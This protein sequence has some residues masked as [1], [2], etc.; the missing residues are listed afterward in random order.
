MQGV[1]KE[2]VLIEKKE[3]K[4]GSKEFVLIE[5]NDFYISIY[6]KESPSVWPHLAMRT[7]TVLTPCEQGAVH[8][9]LLCTAS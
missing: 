6:N 4:K 1:S 2:F 8:Y 7:N 5:N 9:P 3:L